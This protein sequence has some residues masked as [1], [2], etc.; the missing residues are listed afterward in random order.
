MATKL[1][2][3]CFFVIAF[4]FLIVA[5]LAAYWPSLLFPDEEPQQPSVG[6]VLVH[7]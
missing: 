4:G 1:L 3:W 5:V 2:K 7:Y 6:D